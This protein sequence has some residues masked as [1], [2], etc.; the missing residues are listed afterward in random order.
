VRLNS[1]V[2][3]IAERVLP[4]A[5]ALYTNRK[6]VRPESTQLLPQ[7][8]PWPEEVSELLRQSEA[9]MRSL[10]AKGPGL[11][12]VCAITVT[13]IAVTI[14]SGW[15][16][17]AWWS[18]TLLLISVIYAVMSL[19]AP[20]HMVGPRRRFV[21]TLDDLVHLTTKPNPARELTQIKATRATLNMAEALKLANL[22]SACRDSLCISLLAILAW[23]LLTLAPLTSSQDHQYPCGDGC[24]VKS[25]SSL[26][27]DAG[28]SAEP[29]ASHVSSACES[30]RTRPGVGRAAT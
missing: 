6:Y 29:R 30:A 19:W 23:L 18:R 7:R 3:L 28:S 17:S 27:P 22:Q 16:E 25:S 15:E 8:E 12:A 2:W 1:W 4:L 13:A 26:P 21:V 9:Q 10:E 14:S 20:L 5:V 11:A 24:A